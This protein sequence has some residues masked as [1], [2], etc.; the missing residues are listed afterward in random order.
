MHEPTQSIR[1]K[2]STAFPNSASST[3]CKTAIVVCTWK[4]LTCLRSTIEWVRPGS[5]IRHVPGVF[6]K[7]DPGVGW[8]HKRRVRSRMTARTTPDVPGTRN[9]FRY[10]VH[11]VCGVARHV[12]VST[13]WNISVKYIE[14]QKTMI[15]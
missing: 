13:Q 9:Q 11:Y 4:S 15:K 8:R 12:I 7:H 1:N 3:R 5:R 6:V 14:N 2:N 10:G